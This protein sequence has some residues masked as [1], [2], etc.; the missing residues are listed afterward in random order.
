VPRHTVSK[1]AYLRILNETLLRHPAYYAGM[2]FHNI[3]PDGS[4][5]YEIVMPTSV[6]DRV[7]AEQVF[8]EVANEVRQRYVC[9]RSVSTEDNKEMETTEHR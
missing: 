9:A 7:R 8:D 3:L 2:A 4:H 1:D 6:P 5:S